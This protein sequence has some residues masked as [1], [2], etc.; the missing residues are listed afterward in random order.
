MYC[1]TWRNNSEISDSGRGSGD[2]SCHNDCN[3]SNYVIIITIFLLTVVITTEAA[4]VAT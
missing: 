3:S 1:L 4:V 2:N